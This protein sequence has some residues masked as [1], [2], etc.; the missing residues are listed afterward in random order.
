MTSSLTA[1][2]SAQ[3]VGYKPI[4]CPTAL[5]YAGCARMRAVDPSLGARYIVSVI[6]SLWTLHHTVGANP[7]TSHGG[8]LYGS[9]YAGL[10]AARK[11]HT[12]WQR[13]GEGSQGAEVRFRALLRHWAWR[14]LREW[15]HRHQHRCRLPRPVH[16]HRV[17]RLGGRAAPRLLG[18]G[19]RRRLDRARAAERERHDLHL[20]GPETAVFSC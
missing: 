15:G 7:H 11:E 4:T 9:R 18:G 16:H 10:T 3:V 13:G 2:T 12:V 1:S 8:G 14:T 6:S 20:P 17:H 5:L 19:V